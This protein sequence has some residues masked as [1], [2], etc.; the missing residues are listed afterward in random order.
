MLNHY[1][2]MNKKT[3]IIIVPITEILLIIASDRVEYQNK[4]Q[5]LPSNM[6]ICL[7]K[8]KLPV[9][10]KTAQSNKLDSTSFENDSLQE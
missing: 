10:K 1:P 6:S 5:V 4:W 8:M 3:I 2:S 7:Q 9:N